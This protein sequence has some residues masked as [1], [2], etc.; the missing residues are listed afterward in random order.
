MKIYIYIYIYIYILLKNIEVQ[1]WI[2]TVVFLFT[3]LTN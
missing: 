3:I 2:M 1:N